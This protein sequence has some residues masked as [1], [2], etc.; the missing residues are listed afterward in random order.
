M[1]LEHV[2]SVS[3][4]VSELLSCRFVLSQSCC[5]CFS[6]FFNVFCCWYR[7]HDVISP[8]TWVWCTWFPG[9]WCFPDGYADRQQRAS[10]GIQELRPS[11]SPYDIIDDGPT[12][13]NLNGM[14][15]H[16]ITSGLSYGVPQ[17]SMMKW[18]SIFGN[19]SLLPFRLVLFKEIQTCR[20][21]GLDMFG[22]S[23]HVTTTSALTSRITISLVFPV[24]FDGFAVPIQLG[25]LPFLTEFLMTDLVRWVLSS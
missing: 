20:H 10:S 19:V 1:V 23:I 7:Y 17:F 15:T 8:S 24:N 16:G 11:T 6:L 12:S 22:S 4:F 18:S 25:F 14:D 13:V 2:S 5:L 21:Q 9:G 3:G